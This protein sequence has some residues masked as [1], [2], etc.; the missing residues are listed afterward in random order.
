M[1][2]KLATFFRRNGVFQGWLRMVDKAYKVKAATKKNPDLSWGLINYAFV[3]VI[4]QTQEPLASR[5]RFRYTRRQYAAKAFEYGQE[6]M[7][8]AFREGFKTHDLPYTLPLMLLY[9]WV[10]PELTLA[11]KRL[12]ADE[13]LALG[14]HM[15]KMIR[16]H[17]TNNKDLGYNHLIGGGVAMWGD[18][19]GPSYT[20]AQQQLLDA[21]DSI[22]ITNSLGLLRHVFSSAN[23][24]ESQTYHA[25]SYIK[26]SLFVGLLATA[27]NTDYFADVP[28]FRDSVLYNL[29]TTRPRPEQGQYYTWRS[30]TEGHMS[31]QRGARLRH[32]YMHTGQLNGKH[33][34]LAALATWMIEHG[35]GRKGHAAASPKLYKAWTFSPW[36]TQVFY[37]FLWSHEDLMPK[38]PRDIGLPLTKRLGL[39][40]YV[41]RTGFPDKDDPA[42]QD[43]TLIAFHATDVRFCRAHQDTETASFTI[44]K[45]GNLALNAGGNKSGPGATKKGF[46]LNNHVTVYRPTDH[47]RRRGD[48]GLNRRTDC[49]AYPH[50]AYH[51]GGQN[52]QGDVVAEDI[53]N[54]DYDYISYDYTPAW[55]ATKVDYASRQ[56][57]YLRGPVNREYVV[58]FDRINTVDASHVKRWMLWVPFA[59][60]AV[61]GAFV[62][63][64]PERWQSIDT[65]T[66]RVSN[67]YKGNKAHGTMFVRTL[68]PASP[69]IEK[70]G[71][72]NEQFVDFEGEHHARYQKPL[73]DDLKRWIG[74]FR[75][76]I[77]PAQPKH[78]DMFLTVMHV[79]DAYR[80]KAMAPTTRIDTPDGRMVGAYIEDPVQPW[81]ILLGTRPQAISNV[82]YTIRGP[83]AVKHLVVDLDTQAEYEVVNNGT[84]MFTKNSGAAGRLFFSTALQKAAYT[85]E[86][87]K[88]K[89]AAAVP[90]E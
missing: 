4:D 23:W 59:P 87:R 11:Q 68:L 84:P 89:R 60:E 9:D 51:K 18:D 33:A 42:S 54:G 48:G 34:D 52:W 85:F 71:G 67:R 86:I 35:W 43:D 63:M 90:H 80:L 73:S 75:V 17:R 74:A 21:T 27:L 41:M 13:F 38:S 7:R 6:L 65:T 50:P 1:R 20:A 5:F 24:H 32:P 62:S 56:F 49:P 77:R 25:H 76:Q 3:Y 82:Q 31:V 37:R 58:V 45:F 39:G 70:I 36:Q 66:L 88:V 22:W 28:F 57:L 16:P 55:D 72:T 53:N 8:R 46:F 61:D 40:T 19:L 29:Y 2:S 14:T 64:Q 78:Y 26:A 81:L 10:Y 44:E 47:K 79:G 30:N 69:I 83:G 15:P 12:L